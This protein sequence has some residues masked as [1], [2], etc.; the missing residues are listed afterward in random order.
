MIGNISYYPIVFQINKKTQLVYAS[1]PI[2]LLV[3]QKK[4]G[5][6]RTM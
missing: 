4:H 5:S 6:T 2:A 3:T 1:T